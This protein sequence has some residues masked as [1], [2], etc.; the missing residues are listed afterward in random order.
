VKGGGKEQKMVV[1]RK[2][3]GED[4]PNHKKAWRA[5]QHHLEEMEKGQKAAEKRLAHGHRARKKNASKRIGMRWPT[6]II[7]R[8]G[9]RVHVKVNRG[10]AEKKSQQINHGR[11]R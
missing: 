9:I 3:E 2:K 10:G 11:L 7:R 1:E 8:G 4:R 6:R 5:N